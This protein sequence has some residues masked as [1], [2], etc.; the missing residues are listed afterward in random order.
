MDAVD[1]LQKK[2]SRTAIAGDADDFKE[3][4]A[5]LAVEPGAASGNAEVLAREARNDAIHCAMPCCSVEGAKVGPDRSVIQ[6]AFLHARCQ[7]C[8]GVCFPLDVTDGASL[9]AQVAEPGSQS[10]AKHANAGAEFDG[11]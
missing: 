11:M 2:V 6:A 7:D 1:V 10:F 4:A 5:S 3:Q 8:A 9:S